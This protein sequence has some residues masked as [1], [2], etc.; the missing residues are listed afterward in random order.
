LVFM[1]NGIE[2]PYNE[3]VCDIESSIV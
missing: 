3:R 1:C 2:S